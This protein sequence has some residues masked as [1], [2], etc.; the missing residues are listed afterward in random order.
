VWVSVQVG[1]EQ[2]PWSSLLLN[3]KEFYPGAGLET[4]QDLGRTFKMN[5][6]RT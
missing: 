3:A 6:C 4:S 1:A 2:Q 5:P